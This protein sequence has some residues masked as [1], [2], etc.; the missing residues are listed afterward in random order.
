MSIKIG[1]KLPPFS[2]VATSNKTLTENDLLNH[3]TVIY[4][5]PKDSTPGCTTEGLDFTALSPEFT[6]LNTQI[7]GASLDSMKRH[8]N[9]IAK[10]NFSFD[11][12]SDPEGEFCDLFGVYQMKKNF[13]KEYMGIVRSTFI[14]NESGELIKEWRNVKVKGHAQ[15]VLDTINSLQNN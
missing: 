8:D 3:Y 14:F 10:Q 13:G 11:L 7:Y 6:K 2:V 12:I 4:F 1:E 9:F 5:Y 15:E